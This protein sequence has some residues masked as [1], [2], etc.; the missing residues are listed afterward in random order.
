MTRD[1]NVVE[2]PVRGVPV[3]GPGRPRRK[4]T[5]APWWLWGAAVAVLLPVAVPVA[6]LLLRVVEASDSAWA[7][8]LSGSTARLLVRSLLFTAAVTASAITV[9]V[10]GAWL[11]T[12]TDLKGRRIWGVLFALPL[13]VPSYVLAMVLISATGP[14]GLVSDLTGLEIP[15][16]VGLPGAW[17]TLTLATYPYVYLIVAAALVRSD[18]A[19]EEAAKG[20]GASPIR[21]FRTVILPHLRTAIG[22]SGLL[23]ALYT[24]SDFGAVS[25]MR[26]DS[27]TRV[28]YA[29]YAGRLDRTP[30][31]V[32]SIV[33]L[34]A[35]LAIITAERWTRGGG[36]HFSAKP[37]RPPA[38]Y[39]LQ[40]PMRLGGQGFL[41]LVVGAGVAVPVGVLVAWVVRGISSGN[42][43]TIP[44]D[45]MGT[46]FL[47]A[48]LAAVFAV[49]G[50]IPIVVL[51]VRHPSRRSA[52]VERAA[53]VLF[54]LPHI[55][56]AIAAAAFTVRYARPVYQSLL[57]LV[58]VYASM[59]LAQATGPAKAALLQVDPVLDDASRS[60]GASRGATLRRLTI[61]LMSKGL[62][63]GGLLVFVTTMKE[64]PVTLL[65]RPS[66][67]ST[68]AIRIWSS[69][70]ELLY[71]SAAVSSLLLLAVSVLPV[72][73]LS[74]KPKNLS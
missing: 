70:D 2:V 34:V 25:L 11:L 73:F 37:T 55:T 53:Y 43:V 9:G 5:R 68:L 64:L 16:L 66:G 47:V 65:L 19:L 36:S 50:S 71:T 33:L 45:A 24:L 58:V 72:Y 15:H 54:G 56:V 60:L 49:V 59:F 32:L 28:I 61:P 67:F 20:L 18:P 14:R 7:T 29:Q 23:V 13:V 3:A 30:A 52:F 74:I 42:D 1:G 31:I 10:T 46:S 41:G 39:R 63:A 4:A 17:L 38:P 62:F 57:V 51:A 48:V 26:F 8:L 44:W 6:A 21:V 22:A 69:A 35:A 27:F 40:Q 12:R